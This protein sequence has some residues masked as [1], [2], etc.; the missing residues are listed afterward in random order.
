MNDYTAGDTPLTASVFENQIEAVRLLINWIQVSQSDAR[1]CSADVNK[2]DNRECSAP[3]SQSDDTKCTVSINKPDGNG[4]NALL[5]AAL[6]GFMEIAQILVEAGAD[7]NYTDYEGRRPIH[8]ATE[9][10]NIEIIEILVEGGADL[11]CQ[12]NAGWRPIHHAAQI[13]HTGIIELSLQSGVSVNTINLY[14]NETPL[15]LAA[16]EGH[17]QTVQFLLS[18]GADIEMKDCAE[19]TALHLAAEF[20]RI[21]TVDTLIKAGAE[22]NCLNDGFCTPLIVGGRVSKIISFSSILHHQLFYM[23]VTNFITYQP[24]LATPHRSVT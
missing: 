17:T 20:G 16:I 1:E 6:Y 21:D 24:S 23:L 5:I 9:F 14:K 19:N 7:V 22:V 15:M 2:S 3:V 18:K 4:W 10:D 11:N 12:D 8:L 13:G